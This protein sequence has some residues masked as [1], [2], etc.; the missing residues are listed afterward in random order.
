MTFEQRQQ[1]QLDRILRW[2][3]GFVVL[4]LLGLV[5]A[6]V[7]VVQLKVQP[8]EAL[9]PYLD[10][11]TATQREIARRGDIVDSRGRVLATSLV[12][13]RLFVDPAMVANMDALAKELAPRIG[14]HPQ[15]ILQHIHQRTNANP[16]TRYIVLDRELD[17]W[18][19]DAVRQGVGEGTLR[20]VGVEPMLVRRYPHGE[21][22]A[23]VVGFVNIEHDGAGGAE[24]TLEKPLEPDDGSLTYQRDARG[25]VL[26]IEDE[27]YVGKRDGQD[28]RLTIDLVVQEFVE[29]A[30]DKA[31]RAFNARGARCVVMDVVTGDII[32]IADVLRNRKGF[33]EVIPFDDREKHPSWGRQRCVTD[34]YEPGST[35]KPFV[36]AA[37]VDQGKARPSEM[38][39]LPAGP[40]TTSRGRVIRDVHYSGPCT[41]ETV[42]MKSLNGGMAYV[43]ERFSAKG[44]RDVVR[45]FGFGDR[46]N[47]GLPSESAGMVT[48]LKQWR[49]TSQTSV[50][51][52]QEIAVTSMQMARA[53]SAFC[54]D[55][56]MIEPRLAI[57]PDGGGADGRSPMVTVPRRAISEPAALKTREV[58]RSVMTEGTGR[59][60]QSELYEI[61][62]K[63]GTPQLAVPRDRW[64]EFGKKGYFEDRYISN[65]IGGAPFEHPRIVVVLTI[66]DP[67]RRKGHFG[68]VTA[69]PV[70]R[71]IIDFTLSYLGVEPDVKPEKPEAESTLARR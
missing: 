63:T 45:S 56:T 36:W 67:D 68:G 64:R 33:R 44:L 6:L 9:R 1:A 69:A 11:P 21:V 65:F 37:A 35:F 22:G 18:Q 62:G 38:I 66:D 34:P 17:D 50:P 25:R 53:F 52:G 54:R 10:P 60:A 55:G 3:R 24:L 48:P 58:M 26:W 27:S 57:P 15:E 2:G 46:T 8:E 14:A 42:L 28:M 32:A 70:A 12:G 47:C 20:G 51:M 13:Y 59:K 31:A 61:F 41:W 23:S 71:D 29:E 39:P 40:F 43:G 7:R 30:L 49:H 4:I 19:V 16:K 5:I